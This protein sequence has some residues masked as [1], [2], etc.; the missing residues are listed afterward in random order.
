VVDG[1]KGVHGMNRKADFSKVKNGFT[2][3]A[4]KK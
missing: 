4:A 1:T 3:K 2:G